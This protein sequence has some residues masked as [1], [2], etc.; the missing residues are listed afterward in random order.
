MSHAGKKG[1]KK[2]SFSVFLRR[3]NLGGND[4]EREKESRPIL[5]R[6]KGREKR[7][8]Y[9]F[10]TQKDRCACGGR[11]KHHGDVKSKENNDDDRHN[12]D[13]QQHLVDHDDD[14]YHNVDVDDDKC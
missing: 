1:E 13:D 6:K 12:K 8:S 3:R 11:V 10:H 9:R 7:D 14:N 4:F 5:L 2:K